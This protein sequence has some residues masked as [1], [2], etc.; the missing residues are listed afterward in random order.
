MRPDKRNQRLSP[1]GGETASNYL[2]DRM[3]FRSRSKNIDKGTNLDDIPNVKLQM[4]PIDYKGL[5]GS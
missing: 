1:L 3:Y 5:I 4:V 2:G